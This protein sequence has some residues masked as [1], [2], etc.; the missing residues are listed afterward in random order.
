MLRIATLCFD[1]TAPL[2][3]VL[4]DATLPLRLRVRCGVFSNAR[5]LGIQYIVPDGD[6]MSC[7]AA[8]RGNPSPLKRKNM[9]GRAGNKVRVMRMRAGPCT[10]ACVSACVD[11]MGQVHVSLRVHERE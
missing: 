6:W 4:L 3:H 8:S 10:C 5:D 1:N 2:T 11:H 9:M 7:V